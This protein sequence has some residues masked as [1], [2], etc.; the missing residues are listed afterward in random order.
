MGSS[1]IGLWLNNSVYAVKKKT[2][3]SVSH[4]CSIILNLSQWI[5]KFLFITSAV[6]F[7]LQFTKT[8]L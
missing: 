8:V 6:A 7:K 5:S 3:W 1:R 2:V 4:K